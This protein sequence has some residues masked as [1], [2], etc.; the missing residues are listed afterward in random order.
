MTAAAQAARIDA[1][2]LLIAA[3]Q[4]SRPDGYPKPL[5]GQTAKQ[6]FDTAFTLVTKHQGFCTG[7]FEPELR[8]ALHR[9]DLFNTPIYRKPPDLKP[10]QL[11][12]D[13]KA[14]ERG[15]LDGR[16]LELA[17]LA[18]PIQVFFLHIQGSGRIRLDDGQILR[19]GF[20]GKN[21][22]PYKSIGKVLVE[23]GLFSLEEITAQ[24]I[25]D[26]LAAHPDDADRVM[27]ENPSYV[28]FDTRP[29][30]I[31]SDGPIGT[32]GVPLTALIS[33]AADPKHHP[34]GSLIY[35]EHDPA[36][37]LK[38]N[39]AIVQDTGGAIKGPGRIDLFTGS[40]DESGLVAGE[41]K[42]PVRITTFAP[43]KT[44]T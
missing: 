12:H 8:G 4:L 31:E 26:W 9:S 6:F 35:I 19:V 27:N 7:Y 15:A 30:L 23:R 37:G 34:L 36:T 22:H 32:A 17:W 3:Y 42:H 20:A 21:G 18:D 38:D 11:Y 29:H 33:V 41:L 1:T 2:D 40:G 39:Y 44:P 43:K 25:K 13:R 16:G 28:F 14:I 24:V 5:F 10:D